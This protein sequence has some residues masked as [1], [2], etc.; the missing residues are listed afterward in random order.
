MLLASKEAGERRRR[1]NVL[2]AHWLLLLPLCTPCLRPA[3]SAHPHP[4]R[5][6]PPR[7]M[8]QGRKAKF[9]PGWDCHGLP[10]ELKVLQSM[11]ESERRALTPLQLRQKAAEFALKTVDA[12][13]E[14]FQRWVLA[15]GAGA[16]VPGVWARRPRVLLRPPAWP[17]KEP[18]APAV[19]PL[20]RAAAAALLPIN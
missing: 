19:A 20:L 16:W 8:L 17:P 10:I 4:R 18:A 14:Q 15:L 3:P 11:K 1:C 6:V 5:A 7:P 13:R 9:V 12:Q 2:A